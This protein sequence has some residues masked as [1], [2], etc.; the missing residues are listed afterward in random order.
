MCEAATHQ[1]IAELEHGRKET[2]VLLEEAQQEYDSQ[3]SH[4][5]N[6]AITWFSIPFVHMSNFS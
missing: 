1:L 4:H 3:F 6:T 5:F 2:K